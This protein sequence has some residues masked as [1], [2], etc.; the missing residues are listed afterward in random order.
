[1]T[2]QQYEQLL[3]GNNSSQ[4]QSFGSIPKRSTGSVGDLQDQLAGT[5]GG[6]IGQ[7]LGTVLDPVTFGLGTEAGGAIGGG[8][9]QGGAEAVREIQAGKGLNWGDIGSQAVQGGALGAIPLVDESKGAALA[10]EAGGDAAK[11]SFINKA[12]TKL[13]NPKAL[14]A[15]TMLKRTG[16]RA[17]T[18]FAGGAVAQAAQNAQQGQNPL[19]MNDLTGGAETGAVNAMIPGGMNLLQRGLRTIPPEVYQRTVGGTIN[20]LQ[21]LY[22]KSASAFVGDQAVNTAIADDIIPTQIDGRGNKVAGELMTFD[23]PEVDAN[24]NQT[25][26]MIKGNVKESINRARQKASSI[27][28]DLQKLLPG[29][30]GG[31]NY[32]KDLKPTIDNFIMQHYGQIDQ[33]LMKAGKGTSTQ[34]KNDIQTLASKAS[35]APEEVKNVMNLLA[36][37]GNKGLKTGQGMGSV[38][39]LNSLK[40]IVGEG[41]D[42]WNGLYDNLKNMVEDKSGNADQIQNLNSHARTLI[43]MKQQMRKFDTTGT[44]DPVSADDADTAL[45]KGPFGKTIGMS[46]DKTKSKSLLIPQALAA[47]AAGAG[48]YMLGGATGGLTA[49]GGTA[50]A[51]Y[52]LAA[53]GKSGME[54][55]LEN[56]DVL[57]S[58]ADIIK[59]GGPTASAIQSL[60]QQ[61]L[62]HNPLQANNPTP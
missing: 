26:K 36:G 56:P 10:A 38:K 14:T 44:K 30:P 7:A 54:R 15:D 17:G 57:N 21:A 13:L 29:E 43:Q 47:L 55:L 4:T 9:G 48:G 42:S 51:P 2:K 33:G 39:T 46:V 58:M 25:G 12:L 31:V 23:H 61:K 20:A 1:M 5:G 22:N 11:T 34:F 32:E 49:G 19:Q 35:I 50:V 18:G 45:E 41:N 60:L 3:K 16:I 28:S 59:A 37:S 27:E 24:G 52:L 62:A 8:L 6:T 40:R 53:T